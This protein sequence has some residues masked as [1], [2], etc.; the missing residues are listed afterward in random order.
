MFCISP[1]EKCRPPALHIQSVGKDPF[2]ARL[3]PFKHFRESFTVTA[4][5]NPD[6]N[7][8]KLTTYTWEIASVDKESGMFNMIYRFGKVQRQKVMTL[9]LRWIRPPGL[10]YI[11]CLARNA[12]QTGVHV[13]TYDFGFFET[14]PMKPL[15]CV[16]KPSKG[17]AVLGKFNLNCRGGYEGREAIGYTVTVDSNIGSP[18]DSEWKSLNRT[19]ALPFGNPKDDNHVKVMVQAKFLSMPSLFDDVV[20]QVRYVIKRYKLVMLV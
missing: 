16:V 7:V 4:I 10:Q 19:V 8:T 5:L 17:K 13:F 9:W 20:V 14:V 11:R 2:N 6:C 15:R 18:V 3:V 1:P 12:D